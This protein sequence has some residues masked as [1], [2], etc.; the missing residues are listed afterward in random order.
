MNRAAAITGMGCVT[1]AGA[2]VQ[3]TWAALLDGKVLAEH[4]P[5]EAEMPEHWTARA[6][7]SAVLEP[8]LTGLSY[9]RPARTTILAMAAA[10][11]CWQS[12]CLNEQMDQHRT[13]CA[14]SRNF[15]QHDTVAQYNRVLWEK[16]PAAVSGLQ[17]VQT[18]GNTVLGKI[19]LDLHLR[20]PSILN[21]GA[22]VLGLA[23]DNLR[24]ND[25]DAMLVGGVDELS[26]YALTRV[27]LGGLA[28]LSEQPS[29]PYDRRR[30]G[31]VP[32]E[33]AA[34]L[35]LETPESAKSG[36]RKILGY[37]RG[38]AS[39]TDR[40]PSSFECSAEDIAEC[41][42][43]ALADAEMVADEIAF[44]C[45]AGN[46]LPDFDRAELR[47]LETV[48]PTPPPLYSCKGALGE[49]WGAA[50]YLSVI[51]V[52][53]AFSSGQLP[54]TAGTT[55]PEDCRVPVIIESAAPINR[56]ATLVLSLDMSG[57]DSAYILTA[58]P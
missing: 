4:H 57:Q 45:G 6:P 17:F 51:S 23:L 7:E 36:D 41:V 30:Q 29:G 1:V 43:R 38:H 46:R 26:L 39:V 37:L 16:G 8:M 42:R 28:V 44:V 24:D 18:I 15:G 54:P 12:L 49:T 21:F 32:G 11:E 52:L 56:G 19:S 48:F 25:A 47:A 3:K 13:G 20:G 35:F 10:Q 22:P 2:G 14:M 9:P 33:A 31:L 53:L 5:S 27:C 34:F 40:S 50:A 58:E 55:E